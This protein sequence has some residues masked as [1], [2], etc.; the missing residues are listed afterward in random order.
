MS[1]G[2]GK[3]SL[4]AESIYR[5]KD[6]PFVDDHTRHVVAHDGVEPFLEVGG[7]ALEGLVP[8]HPHHVV[9][10]LRP[11]LLEHCDAL[12]AEELRV[13]NPPEVPPMGAAGGEHY[14]L[15][16]RHDLVCQRGRPVQEG[17]VMVLEHLSCHLRRRHHNARPAS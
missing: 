15:V 17:G 11:C 13:A 16:T 1:L 3:I 5:S 12:G 7:V 6:V 2:E 8:Q 4:T 9:N 10:L 14:V